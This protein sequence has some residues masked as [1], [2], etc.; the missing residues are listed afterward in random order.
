M[1]VFSSGHYIL[2]GWNRRTTFRR[3]IVSRSSGKGNCAYSVWPL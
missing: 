1:E 3:Q 2:S